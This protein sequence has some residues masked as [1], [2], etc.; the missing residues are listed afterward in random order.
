MSAEQRLQELGLELPAAPSA[1]AVYKPALT[2]G[3]LVYTSG[4]LPI[5]SDGSLMTGTVGG[6]VDEA[7]GKEAAQQA[8]LNLLATLKSHCGSL[9]KVK[10]VV[11]IFGLVNSKDDFVQQPGVINGCSELMKNVF[12]DEAGV[13]TRSAVGVNTLPL[14]VAVEIEAIFEIEV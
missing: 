7:F 6:D 10:R 8:G 1:V 14:G 12:G 3:N 11:K 4:H 13:G 5:K 2:V 9:D